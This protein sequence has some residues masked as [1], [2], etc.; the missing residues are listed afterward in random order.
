MD[1]SFWLVAKQVNLHSRSKV[2]YY[3]DQIERIVLFINTNAHKNASTKCNK[4]VPCAVWKLLSK[5]PGLITVFQKSLKS[6][7]LKQLF[8]FACAIV[9]PRKFK[10]K[11]L[12]MRH[13][14]TIFKHHVI[15]C[16]RMVEIFL[17]AFFKK[18]RHFFDKRNVSEK[19]LLPFLRL[20][21]LLRKRNL[22]GWWSLLVQKK[23]L[24][25]QMDKKAIS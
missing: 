25:F 22:E 9:L 15:K 4:K 8:D 23:I 24:F 14:L 18:V 16:M 10:K 6:L 5:C 2:S 7:I 12:K 13:I 17:K 1:W 3:I 19:S 20:W 11:K 21:G